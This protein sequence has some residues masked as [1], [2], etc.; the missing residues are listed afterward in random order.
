MRDGKIF[1][2]II[3]IKPDDTPITRFEFLKGMAISEQQ[4]KDGKVIDVEDILKEIETSD[5]SE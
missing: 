3:G 5:F 2:E 4:I 1:E